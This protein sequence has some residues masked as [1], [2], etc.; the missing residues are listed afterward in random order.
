VKRWLF[1]VALVGCGDNVSDES[2]AIDGAMCKHLSSWNLFDDIAAQQPAA[3]VIPYDLNTP[4][5]SD[6][7]TK[8]RF[9]RLPEGQQAHWTAD[10]VIDLPVGSVLVKTFSYLH[11]RRDASLGK[12]LIETRVLV[13]GESGW[14]GS[15]YL[16][17]DSRDDAQLAIAGAIVDTSWIHDD[18]SQRTNSYVVPNQNQCKN[19][20]AEHDSVLTPLGPKARH[21][22]P[23]RLQALVDAGAL[24][25]APPADQWPTPIVSLDYAGHTPTGTLDQRARQWLD[26]NCS[27]C[28]NP[29][30]AARTSGLFLDWDE[31]D[32]A[33]V[34]L[35]KSPVATGR[36]SGGLSYDISPGQPDQS[37][38]VFRMSS[39][40]PEIRM[41]ELGRNLVHE[42][43]VAL[44]REWIGAMQG[45]CAR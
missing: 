12:D 24:A 35:C 30:G 16:Y 15:S 44:V 26:I 11:D 39:T 8:D 14:H 5:F 23:E 4:L 6:Y 10:G 31:T 43:G 25:D 45:S 38:I 17:G 37:I 42:E 19:C 28:H 36:G 20:H 13:H 34:G 33:K 2:C 27:Y 18:G 9:I 7:A 32:M 22:Q 41:P 29:K 3:G 40:E 21:V 1:A